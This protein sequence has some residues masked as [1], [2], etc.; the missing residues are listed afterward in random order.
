MA[1]IEVPMVT[2]SFSLNILWQ[3]NRANVI[4]SGLEYANKFS[5]ST[6]N[7]QVKDKTIQLPYNL[8]VNE[9]LSV[10]NKSMLTSTLFSITIKY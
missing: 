7:K 2:F 4:P 3:P 10:Y 6:G 5:A 8:G 9:K 1:S